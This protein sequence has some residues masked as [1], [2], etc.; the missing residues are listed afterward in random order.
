MKTFRTYEL[1]KNFYKE[2]QSTP[3]LKGL[4]GSMKDQFERALLSIPLNLAEGSAKTSSK[5]RKKF[6]R[7]A[8]GSL[9]EVQCLLDL[10]ADEI[11]IQK[12]DQLGAC[13]YKLCE[14]T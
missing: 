3:A 9:R 6:Y 7:I 4:K 8:L 2:C 12:A 5:E 10:V 1:A 13:L 11:L 14:K